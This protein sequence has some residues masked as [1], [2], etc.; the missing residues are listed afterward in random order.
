MKTVFEILDQDLFLFPALVTDFHLEGHFTEL[1]HGI[2]MV[3]LTIYYSSAKAYQY[4]QVFW[5]LDH[6]IERRMVLSHE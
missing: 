1:D 2:A 6:K 5:L 3:F 4:Q